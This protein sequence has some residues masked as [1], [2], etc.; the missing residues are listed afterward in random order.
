M[1]AKHFLTNP[2]VE[3]ALIALQRAVTP[4]DVWAACVQLMRSALPIYHVMLGLPSL[5]ISPMFMRATLAIP[6]VPRFAQLAPLNNVIRDSP[7]IPVSRMSDH[8]SLD[9]PEGQSFMEEFLI[10]MGWRHAAAL[11]F[12][13]AQGS[14]I[15]QLS[16][17]RTEQQGDFTNDEI[18]LLRSLH[19]HVDAVVQRLLA[20]EGTLASHLSLDY[21]ISSLPLPIIVVGWD[22]AMQFSNPAARDALSAWLHP[23]AGL[24]PSSAHKALRTLPPEITAACTELKRAW[25]Q[26]AAAND[27]SRIQRSTALEHKSV[28]GFQAEIQL[29]ESRTGRS[30]QPSFAIHFQL[31]AT[32]NNEVGRAL[33]GLSKLSRAEREVVRLAASGDDNADIA[34]R[35]GVSLSTVRTHLRNVFRKLGI[36]SRSRLAPLLP[37]F[38]S[39]APGGVP[40]P[41]RAR[42]GAKRRAR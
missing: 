39:T 25:E 33:G 19:T 31:P 2:K 26:A 5:G 32:T 9:S 21:A 42:T 12:W 8:F 24:T 18:A 23:G 35:L 37:A 34:L 38:Q 4:D 10:P 6:D 7:M 22:G 16:M 1:A 28:S 11:L 41:A 13:T 36:S 20:L 15:G 14:F 30:L 40:S 3:T 27:F 17:I 29:V